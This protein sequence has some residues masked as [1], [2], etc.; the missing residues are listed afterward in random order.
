[1]P[2]VC[3]HCGAQMPDVSSFCAACGSPIGE[4]APP[5]GTT[6]G[7]KDN[8]AGAIAYLTCIPAIAF[9]LVEPYKRNRFIRFHSF[10]SIFLTLAGIL[11]WILLKVVFALLSFIPFL[12]HFVVLLIIMVTFLGWLILWMVLLV[13]ALQGEIFKLPMIGDLA[14]QKANSI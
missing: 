13:K 7:L 8:I 5:L 9:L 12:G 10:Q 14:Q 1:M 2:R 11:A 6:G 3:S 4:A